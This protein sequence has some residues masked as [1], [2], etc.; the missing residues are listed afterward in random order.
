MIAVQHDPYASVHAQGRLVRAFNGTNPC[1][2]NGKRTGQCK[3]FRLYLG[4]PC[5][6]SK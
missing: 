4:V 5:T 3:L 6:C 1:N 2:G